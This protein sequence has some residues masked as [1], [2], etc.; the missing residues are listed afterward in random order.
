MNIQ[1]VQID[2]IN[3]SKRYQNFS[4]KLK[5]DITKD[6]NNYFTSIARVPGYVILKSFKE[7]RKLFIEKIIVFFK[8]YFLISKMSGYS[9][10]NFSNIKKFSKLVISWTTVKNFKSNGEY[11]DRYFRTNSRRYKNTLWFLIS[12]DGILP[13]KVDKNIVILSQK[14]FN[15]INFS[16]LLKVTFIKFIKHNFSFRNL[17]SSLSFY[18]HLSEIVLNKIYPLFENK[19]L[20]L[21]LMP[22]EAQPFQ[23]YLFKNIKK[24]NKKVKTIGYVHATQ[25][26]PIHLLHR[27][28]APD[29]LLVHGKDQKHHCTKYLDWPKSSIKLIPSLRFKKKDNFDFKNRIFLPYYIS[30]HHFYFSEFEKIISNLKNK[31]VKPLQIINHPTMSR[32]K[33][34]IKL[35]KNL[36]SL[37]LKNKKKFSS[38][39]KKSLTFILGGTSTVLEALER[40]YSFI[41]ICAEPIFERYS[42]AFWPNIK[43]NKISNNSYKY[44][45][46]KPETCIKFSNGKDL[47]IK[48]CLN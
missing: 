28:G 14:N 26:Y 24:L 43:L 36:S 46:K 7:K 20:D 9:L 23:N 34:H 2:L 12:S 35:I 48:N 44:S 5:I 4:K 16:Y 33:S 13:K 39:A 3:Q 17:I 21:L 8:N 29:K 25:P 10:Y 6:A 40:K 30:D 41:H 1:K 15:Q 31:S 27:D 18:S 37:I 45:L 19:N 32:S 38:K 22:Y 47:F 11:I 42:S